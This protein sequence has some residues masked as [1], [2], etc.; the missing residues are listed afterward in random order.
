MELSNCPEVKDFL[1]SPTH[2]YLLLLLEMK[3]TYFPL[4]TPF[5]VV[6]VGPTSLPHLRE[7]AFSLA[8]ERSPLILDTVIGTELGT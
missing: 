6:Q 4:G 8:N 2:F 7:G 5:H 1:F 3:H